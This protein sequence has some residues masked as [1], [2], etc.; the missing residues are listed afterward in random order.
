VSLFLCPSDEARG[1]IPGR[2]YAG[3]NYA[4]CN[5]T[6]VVFDAAGAIAAHLP[7]GNGNGAFAQTPVRIADILDGTSNTAAFSENLMGDGQPIAALPSDPRTIRLAVLEVPGGAD[8]TPADCEAGNGVWNPRRG[9]KWTDGHYGNTLYNHFYLPNADGKWDCGNGSHNKGLT[10]AR[11]N[12][13]GGVNLL[14]CDG[15]VRFV[16]SSLAPAPWRALSTR[17]GGEVPGDL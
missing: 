16:R 8:T 2:Q 12:H 6:G 10:A 5:G 13:P 7:I 3:T 1:R 17:A 9:E 11:S 4:A 14:L 15:S